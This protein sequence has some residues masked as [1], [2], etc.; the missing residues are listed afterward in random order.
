MVIKGGNGVYLLLPLEPI[1]QPKTIGANLP[2]GIFKYSL[3][4]QMQDD[5]NCNGVSSFQNLILV[6]KY[7]VKVFV[8]TY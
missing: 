3:I 2:N 8:F 6:K 1:I 5:T 4:F 7:F